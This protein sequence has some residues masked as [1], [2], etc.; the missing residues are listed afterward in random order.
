[1]LSF[2]TIHS[3]QR[4]IEESFI[5]RLYIDE[6]CGVNGHVH[7]YCLSCFL[8]NCDE[9]F[10]GQEQNRCTF[11][12][13]SKVLRGGLLTRGGYFSTGLLGVFIRGRDLLLRFAINSCFSF[14]GLCT[15]C[16][17]NGSKIG[18]GL[19]FLNLSL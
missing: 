17:I 10:G 16:A 3:R 8:R 6:G 7:F 14:D 11:I 5:K 15:I 18:L 2:M 12:V 4:T 9:V 19:F 13:D 1:M